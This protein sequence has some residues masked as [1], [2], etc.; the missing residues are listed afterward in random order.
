M[1]IGS[2]GW[3]PKGDK[4]GLTNETIRGVNSGIQRLTMITYGGDFFC[5]L[6]K[7]FNE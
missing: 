7:N 4:V 6:I 3:K 5:T 2:R 1:N